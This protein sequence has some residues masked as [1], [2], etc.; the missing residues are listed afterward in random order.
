MKNQKQ[1]FLFILILIVLFFT[2][3]LELP[4]LLNLET[5]KQQKDLL[6]D[7]LSKNYWLSVIM[8]ILLYCLVS[9]F[10]MPGA[11]PL[12][13]VGGF[14]F[15]TFPAMLYIL[16][17]ATTGAG[18]CFL[19]V[20]YLI[21]K[22]L[23]KRYKVSLNTFNQELKKRGAYYLLSLR[24]I[25]IFPFFLVNIL[26]G[27]TNISLKTFL[28]T[29]FIGII[30]GSFVLSYTGQQLHTIETISDVFTLEVLVTFGLLALL[31]LMP[32]L[33][34]RLKQRFDGKK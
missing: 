16:I 17:G 7:A 30:P 24:L 26:S 2:Y 28:L 33:F 21:G 14:L 34:K 15:G 6:Q 32:I 12:S 20:R 3:Y 23:Q 31:A 29:T 27:L 10:G 19:L 1:I 22:P 4:K 13:L 18:L 5:L 8:Y 9:T 25:A 11:A